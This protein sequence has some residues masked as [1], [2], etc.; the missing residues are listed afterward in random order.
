MK[1]KLD[2]NLPRLARDALAALGHDVHTA[3][4]EGLLGAA[5]D[6]VLQACNA[7]QR[8]L[9]TLDLAFGDIRLY[10]PGTH[11]G[12]W[13]LRP[14][15]QTIRAMTDLLHAGLRLAATERVQGQLWVIDEQ[16]IRIRDARAE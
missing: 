12:I 6:A 2:E 11:A 13:V 7:E 9:L 3:G 1:F 16:R 10:Q 14:A 5:D 8:V 4:D 15:K